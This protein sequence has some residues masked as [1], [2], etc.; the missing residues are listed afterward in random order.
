M[1]SERRQI[2]ER[3]RS[4]GAGEA[5]KI[6]GAKERDLLEIESE[7]YRQ[8]Q[9]IQGRADAEASG[10]YA[11]A[12]NQNPEAREFY[13]FTRSLDTYLEAFAKGTTMIFGSDTGLF[14]YF[15]G[16]GGTG[17]AGSLRPPDSS[18]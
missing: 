2:A 16:G 9:Q 15:K 5:A 14:R 4:E 10:I 18:R 11:G 12:Y 13:A 1:T 6:L 8:V 7:A 3:F 17:S